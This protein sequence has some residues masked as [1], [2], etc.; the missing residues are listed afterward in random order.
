[1]GN[2]KSLLFDITF[3]LPALY[4]DRNHD[5]DINNRYR[6]IEEVDRE[7]S[8]GLKG[9]CGDGQ[10][11]GYQSHRIDRTI[12][13]QSQ[14]KEEWQDVQKAGAVSARGRGIQEKYCNDQDNADR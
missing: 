2:V 4:P 14:A 5:P 10:D 11:R 3:E 7:C 13:G 9:H 1:M 12:V 8:G 6:A